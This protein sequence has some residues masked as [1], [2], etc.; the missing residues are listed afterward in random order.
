MTSLGPLCWTATLSIVLAR[1][2]TIFC[3]IGITAPSDEQRTAPLCTAEVASIGVA[4]EECDDFSPE[5]PALFL[6]GLGSGGWGRLRRL[7][8]SGRRCYV[9][10]H[11]QAPCF[12]GAR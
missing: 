10:M 4:N 7:S 2:H 9:S 5:A 3:P 6:P 11:T 8:R 1:R 12:Q